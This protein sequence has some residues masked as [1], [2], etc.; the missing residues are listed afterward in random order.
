MPRYTADEDQGLLA[1]L[2]PANAEA[3]SL[4]TLRRQFAEM[5][6]DKQ[7]ATLA[8]VAKL[9]SERP[10]SYLARHASQIYGI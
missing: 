9:M 10:E 6:A 4:R 5:P 8:Y 7:R 1:R 2:H 3:I